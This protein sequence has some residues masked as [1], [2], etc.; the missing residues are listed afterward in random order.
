MSCD[1]YP[2]GNI[3]VTNNTV[4]ETSNYGIAVSSGH[5]ISLTGNRV[6]ATGLLPDNT[7]IFISSDMGNVGIYIW[8]SY[9]DPNWGNIN[10][11]GNTLGW[12][13]ISGGR[14]DKWLGTTPSSFSAITAP[15]PITAATK[16]AE[17]NSWLS[18]V[19]SS[20]RLWRFPS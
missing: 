9:H 20:T 10:A 15:G 3:Q 5:D 1:N 19:N 2:C 16:A 11:S 17:Y 7:P 18:R 13:T 14:N 6:F 12:A 8:N 4:I